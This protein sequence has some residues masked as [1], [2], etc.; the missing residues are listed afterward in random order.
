M[1]RNKYYG[2]ESASITPLEELFSKYEAPLPNE[3]YG[4]GR[5]VP[6]FFEVL[7]VS[8]D[9]IFLILSGTGMLT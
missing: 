7:C 6:V 1:D 3:G 9:S 4:R 8:V 5:L 2:G